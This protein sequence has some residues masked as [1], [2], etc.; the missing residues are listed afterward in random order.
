MSAPCYNCPARRIG[1]HSVCARYI[2]FADQQKR[3][4]NIRLKN[5]E[6]YYS[7]RVLA[8]SNNHRI[9]RLKEET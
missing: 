4:Y 1:C 7:Q 3:I 6:I 2:A 9:N 5:N 8:R